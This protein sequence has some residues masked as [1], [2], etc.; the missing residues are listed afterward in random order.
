MG[1]KLTEWTVVNF[2]TTFKLMASDDSHTAGRAKGM[3][4]AK[5]DQ[6]KTWRGAF[7]GQGGHLKRGPWKGSMGSGSQWAL[8]KL[9]DMDLTSG[10]ATEYLPH[11]GHFYLSE[12]QFPLW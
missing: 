2:S 11:L 12:Y 4:I 7:K 5:P 6:E 10:P 3:E 1:V 9:T 8:G